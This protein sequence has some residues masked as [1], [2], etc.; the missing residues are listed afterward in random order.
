M[1]KTRKR[2]TI[3]PA[4][5]Q[6]ETGVTRFIRKT[7]LNEM[8]KDARINNKAGIKSKTEEVPE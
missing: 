5:T 8:V 7:R 6:Q 2:K 3:V 1:K 4:G